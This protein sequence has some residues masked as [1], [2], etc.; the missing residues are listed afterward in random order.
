MVEEANGLTA[1]FV[2]IVCQ[3]ASQVI[4]GAVHRPP[5]RNAVCADDR[6]DV[7]QSRC[8]GLFEKLVGTIDINICPRHPDGENEWQSGHRLP[9]RA[10][11]ELMGKSLRLIA[12]DFVADQQLRFVRAAARVAQVD[13]LRAKVVAPGE[14]DP[15]QRY[16]SVAIGIA[17]ERLDL[18]NGD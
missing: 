9:F 14:D 12:D 8:L 15:S 6:F 16:G 2:Y 7:S 13:E 18:M 17:R 3:V 11:V 10:E 5:S 4:P 1:V